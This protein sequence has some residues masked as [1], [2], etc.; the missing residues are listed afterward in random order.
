M[1]ELADTELPLSGGIRI[2]VDR[3]EAIAA[4]F[5]TYHAELY[6]FIRRGTRDEAAAEDLL[7]DAFL[8]LA[9]EVSAGRSPDNI[10]AWLY[11]VAANLIVSRARRRRTVVDWLSRQ[12]R[13]DTG[14]VAGPE[15]SILKRERTAEVDG[16]LAGLSSDARTALLLASQGF[17]GEEIAEAI[18]RSPAATRAMMCRARVRVRLELERDELSA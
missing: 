13:G 10:R 17:S 7:Q 18:G 6:G 5:E 4:A 3:R 2:R 1:Q 15:V 16:A 11:R 9:R 12:G 14:T 8:R